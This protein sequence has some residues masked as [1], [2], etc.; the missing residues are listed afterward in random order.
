VA[1]FHFEKQEAPARLIDDEFQFIST[2]FQSPMKLLLAILLC[3]LGCVLLA[4][5]PYRF[6]PIAT[7]A[8]RRRWL[9]SSFRLIGFFVIIF[10]GNTIYRNTAQRELSPF[11]RRKILTSIGSALCAGAA[12][13][14]IVVVAMAGGF[15][16]R[17]DSVTDRGEVDKAPSEKGGH[18]NRAP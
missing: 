10:S 9:A 12:L 14:S 4:A 13:G 15:R 6:N 1:G 11:D 5:S 3:A 2:W 17:I 8:E 18:E 7:E 16:K